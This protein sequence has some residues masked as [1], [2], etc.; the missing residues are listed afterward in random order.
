MILYVLLPV[1]NDCSITVYQLF[2]A[3]SINVWTLHYT[4]PGIMPGASN[5]PSLG[6]SLLCYAAVLTC[7][8]QCYAEE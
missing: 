5:D 3:I 8:A 4:F 7:Y 6:T 2:G 1:S